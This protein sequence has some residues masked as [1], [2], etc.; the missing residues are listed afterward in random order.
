MGDLTISR[1]RRRPQGHGRL[2]ITLGL[3]DDLKGNS[4]VKGNFKG[5]RD[6]EIT[7]DLDL[8]DEYD[9]HVK[10]DLKGAGNLEI[11]LDLDI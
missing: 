1:A 5:V 10:G 4:E 8:E 11:T 9:L 2:E 7:L 6:L 3:K